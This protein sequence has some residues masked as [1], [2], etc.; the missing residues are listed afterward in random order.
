METNPKPNENIDLTRLTPVVKREL[1]RHF[2]S[3]RER[4]I[5]DQVVDI[6]LPYGNQRVRLPKLEV[7]SDLTGMDRS[8][9]CTTLKSLHEMRIVLT[10]HKEGAIVLTVNV[11]SEGWKVKPRVALATTLRGM[12]VV[13]EFNGI[14]AKGDQLNFRVLSPAQFLLPGI[15]DLATVTEFPENL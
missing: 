8:H 14:E 5:A 11:D 13:R 1:R 4:L 7:L 9:V 15:T 12:D 2:L 3:E 6:T 10:H